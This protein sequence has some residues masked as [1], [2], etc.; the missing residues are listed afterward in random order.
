[1]TKGFLKYLL[2][3]LLLLPYACVREDFDMEGHPVD[4]RPGPTPGRLPD[5]N[6]RKV[7]LLYSAGLNSLN[8]YLAKDIEELRGGY[9]PS[10]KSSDDVLLVFSRITDAYSRRGCDPVS[11]VLTRLYVDQEG[12]SICDTLY[13]FPPETVAS[14]G[15]TLMAVLTMIRDRFP[16]SGYGMVFSSHASGW[17]PPGYYNDPSRYDSEYDNGSTVTWR[18]SYSWT[19]FEPNYEFPDL[20]A[21][22][23]I[24]QDLLVGSSREMDLEEF[25]AAIPFK[26]DYLLFDACLMGCVEVAYE[27]KDKAECIGFSQAEVLADGFNYKTLA[28]HLLE[29][30]TPD[31]VSVCR[32]YFEF[33]DSKTGTS[34]SA[35]IALVDCSKMDALALVCR[36]LFGKYREAIRSVDPS[37]VQGYFRFGRHFFYDLEDILIKSGIDAGER[38]A[39]EQAV[40]ACVIYRAAT[41]SFIKTGSSGFDINV[42]SGFS[43]YLPADGTSFLDDYYK[44]HILWNDATG[45][46]E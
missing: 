9:I 33:Y 4:I 25:A 13:T 20:P 41:P 8:G 28:S 26:L 43:M 31:P 32:D 15:E 11:P 29:G 36:D 1:M 42:F 19:S 35:T 39:L 18:R 44:A 14:S 2:P 27:L 16:A 17:T 30:E 6:G 23:S 5:Q 10:D 37:A 21:V 22:K 34:R 3:I 46:V 45:L 12:E 7:L 38:T 24:G 40:D